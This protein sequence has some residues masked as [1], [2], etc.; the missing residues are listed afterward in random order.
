MAIQLLH[1]RSWQ[2]TPR[3]PFFSIWPIARVALATLFKRRLFWVL[4]GFGLL[5]FLMFFFGSFLLDWIEAQV[6]GG[7][8]QI[9]A[10][11]PNRV[12]RSLRRIIQILNGSQDTFAYFFI[13]QGGMVMIVLALAGSLL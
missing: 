8:V 10:V 2:G 1:Y 9:A 12:S 7:S 6:T 3:S 11:D 5:L 4:Y 13:Y